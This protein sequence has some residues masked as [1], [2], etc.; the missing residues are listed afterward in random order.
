VNGLLITNHY[1]LITKY[2][3]QLKKIHPNLQK[4]LI[5]N[6]LIEAN[7]MQQET[8]STIKSGADAVIQSISGSG[9]TTT[10][11]LNVIQ[12]MEKPV[13]ESTR[14]LVLVQNK[15]KV[16]EAVEQ[17]KKLNHYNN[18]RVFGVHEK[19]DIDYDKNQISLGMD[20]LIG[21][22]IRIN[23]M[24][25][26]AGFNMNTIK[27]FVVD[28]VE[29]MLRKREDSIIQR[30]SMSAEK[31]QRLFF[32]SQITERVEI[33]ADRIMIEPLFFEMEE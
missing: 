9:K 24:F 25:S 19:G 7:E 11:L 2:K 10:I 12:R 18:L 26:S 33:L 17:F 6:D 8:F 5:E 32:C 27:M 28:D 4:A 31:T 13:G 14:A 23:E 15:G 22:P 1:S 3:M 20:V 29:E 30:L 21:T 16:I